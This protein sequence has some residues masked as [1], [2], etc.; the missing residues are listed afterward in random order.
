L[1]AICKPYTAFEGWERRRQKVGRT[2]QVRVTHSILFEAGLCLITIPIYMWW[3]DVGAWRALQM[4]A[5]LLI[6]FLIYTFVFTWVFDQIFA[7]P[8][9]KHI[10]A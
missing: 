8:G 5:A 2:V 4:E 6:F 9:S 10:A 3:Y 7:L 1:T